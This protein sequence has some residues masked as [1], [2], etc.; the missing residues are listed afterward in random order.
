MMYPYWKYSGGTEVVFSNIIKNEKG[1]EII[2]V[3]FERPT[4][5]GFDSVRF[6]LPSCK[7]L[8]KDGN[9]T[10]EEIEMFRTIVERGLPSFYRWARQGGIKIA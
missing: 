7:I 2:Y 6:E 9:H 4:E 1:E 10:D 5:H 3:H 8:Y